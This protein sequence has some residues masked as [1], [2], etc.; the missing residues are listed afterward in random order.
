M[1]SKKMEGSEEQKREQ[2]RDARAQGR[3]ASE[4]DATTGASKQRDAKDNDKGKPDG[5]RGRAEHD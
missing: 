5:N 3:Q 2:A 1:V 4:M